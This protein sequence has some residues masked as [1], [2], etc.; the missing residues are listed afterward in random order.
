MREWTAAWW[1]RR[2]VQRLLLSGV[3]PDPE[4]R[5]AF[6]TVPRH[7]FLP[8]APLSEVYRDD[9]VVTRRDEVGVP[10]S[11]SSQPGMMA[12]MLAQLGVEPGHRI[13]EIG[14]GSG[15]N[16]ALLRVLTGPGG[17]VVSVDVDPEL[18]AAARDHL[19]DAGL[20]AEIELA[21]GW[22]GWPAGAPYD[23]IEVTAA[24]TDLAPAWWD[25]LAAAGRLVA[26]LRLAPEIE[27]SVGWCRQGEHLLAQS[28]TPCRF[29]PL[30][31]GADA[32][33]PPLA[34]SEHGRLHRLLRRR[35]RVTAHRGASPPAPDGAVVVR[36]PA[37]TFVVE[38]TG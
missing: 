12:L 18:C 2:L 32:D 19:L 26:P 13:L 11:S 23:G 36:R 16:A 35:V 9:V 20:E 38:P 37:T 28:L 24:A 7:R 14:A 31:G 3:L 15:Y 10:L 34:E 5:R 4:V 27:L 29:L 30:R 1:H 25:Q 17:S 22:L 33:P 6:A 21:D 8:G